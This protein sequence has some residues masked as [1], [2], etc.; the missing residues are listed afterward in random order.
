[1]IEWIII[2]F[3]IF[4]IFVV[5]ASAAGRREDLYVDEGDQ[6]VLFIEPEKDKWMNELASGLDRLKPQENVL[7]Y[8]L[9][10][11]YFQV[12]DRSLQ[13]HVTKSIYG[14]LV[15][16]NFRVFLLRRKR[17][18]AFSKEHEY[19]KAIT[20]PIPLIKNVD[21]DNRMLRLGSIRTIRG[22]KITNFDFEAETSEQA[23]ILKKQIDDLVVQF[24]S[25]KRM[26]KRK[27]KERELVMIP[28]KCP[29]CG[30]ELKATIKKDFYE[31]KFCGTTVL[32]KS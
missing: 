21:V 18:A 27:E 4:I 13:S 8:T 6:K 29:K 26:E 31:C 23:S 12:Y 28:L 7:D 9:G 5:I 16:T 14:V 11:Y 20:I 2:L 1:M 32:I 30:G 3:I 15:L 24:E 17:T 25:V 10:R 22:R 19:T